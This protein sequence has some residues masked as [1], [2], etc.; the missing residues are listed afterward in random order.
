MTQLYKAVF[1]PLPAASL[2]LTVSVVGIHS[3]QNRA[4]RQS[5]LTASFMALFCFQ[6]AFN[7]TFRL[8]INEMFESVKCWGLLVLALMCGEPQVTPSTGLV[9]GLVY[10]FPLVYA[11]S[12]VVF[13][14]CRRWG[15][16]DKSRDDS[17]AIKRPWSGLSG[18]SAALLSRHSSAAME[19][20]PER[21]HSA[22][23]EAARLEI[24]HLWQPLDE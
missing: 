1:W 18:G 6:V 10:I 12:L 21:P 7:T 23:S 20:F 22:V 8:K 15:R 4:L 19:D 11:I 17:H 13:N 3:V 24:Q 14:W 9:I 2:L 16:Q 5:I